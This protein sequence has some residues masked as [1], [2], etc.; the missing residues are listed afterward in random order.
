MELALE[1]E[2]KL[3]KLAIILTIIT[4]SYNIAEG[5]ISVFFGMQ[6]E[7]IALFGFGLDSFVELISAVGVMQ[8]ILRIR[9]NPQSEKTSFERIALRTTGTAFYLLAAGLVLSGGWYVYTNH[10][11]ETTLVGVLVS[12]ASL[13]SMRFLIHYKVKVGTELGSEP[14]LADANCTKTCFNL[15]LVLLFSS[16]AYEFFKIGYFDVIG[17]LGIAYFSLK[18]GKEAFEKANNKSCSS[19]SCSCH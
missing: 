7:S 12:T 5:L 1:R 10:K 9:R 14:I 15:S 8:M 16:L 18:E 2:N 17:S 19:S 11:P 6:D 13:L 4:I 3:Y